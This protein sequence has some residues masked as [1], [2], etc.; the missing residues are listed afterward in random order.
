MARSR[1]CSRLGNLPL[2]TAIA[3]L[4][5]GALAPRA[6]ALS[7]ISDWIPGFATFYG[8]APDGMVRLQSVCT[9][10][11]DLKV[12][13]QGRWRSECVLPPRTSSVI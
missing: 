8:G 10:A 2:P 1:P 9:P 4:L 3:A 13:Y 7:G 11:S 6:A 5:L 12:A